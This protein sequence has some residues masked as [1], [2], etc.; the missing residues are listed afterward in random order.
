MFQSIAGWIGMELETIR[1]C[2]FKPVSECKEKLAEAYN[3]GKAQKGWKTLPLTVKCAVKDCN[4]KFANNEFT[5]AH[6]MMASDPTHQTWKEQHNLQNFK[7]ENDLKKGID[8][9]LESDKQ[10]GPRP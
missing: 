6:I 9:V 3:L 10:A 7:E 1:Y 2:G 5:A 4:A 8:K